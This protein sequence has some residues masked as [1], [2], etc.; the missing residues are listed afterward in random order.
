MRALCNP[1]ASIEDVAAIIRAEPALYAR[2]LRVAN[3][4]YYVQSRSIKSVER[5]LVL[6]GLDAV[7]GIAA[8]ACLN[9]V[10]VKR[11]KTS[12]INPSTILRHSIA[13]GVAAEALAGLVRPALGA[14]A[15]VAGLLHHLGVLVQMSLDAEAMAK[16]IAL[17]SGGD[18]RDIRVL[19][20]ECGAPHHEEIVAL[21][22][23]GWQLPDA[24]RSATGHHHQPLVAQ[25]EYQDLAALVGLGANLGLTT[26]YTFAL[27][28]EPASWDAAVLQRFGLKA[29]DLDPGG[30]LVARIRRL[31]DTLTA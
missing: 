22:T 13:T 21:V 17:R 15:F 31:T 12:L 18:R 25:P 4:A 2:V 8:A 24:I 14:D 7:R 6:L 29:R 28:P 10:V 1:R 23:D 27:E 20:I 16:L 11:E 5:A 19:E 9:G 26:G 3:S 30:S